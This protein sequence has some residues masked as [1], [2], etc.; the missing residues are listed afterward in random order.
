[1]EAL[2]MTKVIIEK[3]NGV[4]KATAVVHMD[5]GGIVNEATKPENVMSLGTGVA[6][7]EAYLKQLIFDRAKDEE[8]TFEEY[9][10][11]IEQYFIYKLNK[12]IGVES[13]PIKRNREGQ[14]EGL[15]KEV[16]IEVK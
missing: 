6:G 2:Q 15:G 7:M 4:E 11:L 9:E 14:I 5:L 13:T 16:E 8:F 3:E 10:E 1:M 12:A